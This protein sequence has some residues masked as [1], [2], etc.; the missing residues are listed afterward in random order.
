MQGTAGSDNQLYKQF[1]VLKP[2]PNCQILFETWKQPAKYYKTTC[3]TDFESKL[4]SVLF[5][6]NLTKTDIQ[7]LFDFLMNTNLWPN[8]I[9][10][11]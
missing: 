9:L 3:Q 10:N 2:I 5:F 8:Q 6:E 11:P 7:L 1:Q 4:R